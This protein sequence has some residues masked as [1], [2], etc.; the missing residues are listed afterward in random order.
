MFVLP[1]GECH[2]ARGKQRRY[3]LQQWM[4]Q[5]ATLG[6]NGAKWQGPAP[7]VDVSAVHDLAQQ[8]DHCGQRREEEPNL[9]QGV[10]GVL[11]AVLVKPLRTH[12]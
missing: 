10:D 3:M 11:L 6:R 5:P 1:C 12:L 7:A 8:H 9:H 4:P 2:M